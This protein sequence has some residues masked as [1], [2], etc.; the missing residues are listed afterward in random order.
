MEPGSKAVHPL[1]PLGT[2][3]PGSEAVHPRIPL[4]TLGLESEAV[5]PRTPLGLG[6]EAVCTLTPLGTLETWLRTEALETL[7]PAVAQGTLQRAVRKSSSEFLK[8]IFR[9]SR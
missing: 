7:Q 5:R 3:E 2:L 6:S 9:N 4:D 8:K 1:T